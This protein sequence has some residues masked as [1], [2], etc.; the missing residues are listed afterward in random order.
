MRWDVMAIMG[1]GVLGILF[2]TANLLFAH[3]QLK[4]EKRRLGKM[5]RFE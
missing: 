4:R 1:L 3:W 2:A 5:A